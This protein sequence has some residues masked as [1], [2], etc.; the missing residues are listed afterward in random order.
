M[1]ETKTLNDLGSNAGL[2]LAKRCPDYDGECIDVADKC[3]CFRGGDFVA[4]AGTVYE[5]DL[6]DG[7]CPFLIGMVSNAD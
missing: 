1:T 3:A 4:K 6:A 7:Y 5:L 2:E